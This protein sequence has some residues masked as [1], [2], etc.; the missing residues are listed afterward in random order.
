M[1]LFLY[2]LNP[3]FGLPL[4]YYMTDSLK[5]SQG[6]IGI[7]GAINST[8]WIVAALLYRRFLGGLTS[9][10]LLNASILFGA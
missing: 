9:K 7:L 2:Y 1:F 3:G 5:F 4:Y 8:G 6:Y 10:Q